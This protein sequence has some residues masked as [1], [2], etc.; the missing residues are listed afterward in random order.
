[1]P[2]K[3]ALHKFYMQQD[4]YAPAVEVRFQEKWPVAGLDQK[5]ALDFRCKC[6]KDLLDEEED[7][8]RTELAEALEAEH[9]AAMTEYYGRA[10]A[11]SNPEL[12][13]AAKMD[14]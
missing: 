3:L 10:E 7:D 8:V 9:E 14:A 13:S 2:R 4:K 12:P 5:F 11:M 6:A 1:M